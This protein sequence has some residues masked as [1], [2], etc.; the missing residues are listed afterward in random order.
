MSLRKNGLLDEEVVPRG[1]HTAVLDWKARQLRVPLWELFGS[2][3]RKYVPI[4]A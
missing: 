1:L 2:Q 4:A 3:V